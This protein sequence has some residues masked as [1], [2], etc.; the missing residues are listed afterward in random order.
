LNSRRWQ[1]LRCSRTGSS[2]ARADDTVV[3]C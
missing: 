3:L 1:T 2:V